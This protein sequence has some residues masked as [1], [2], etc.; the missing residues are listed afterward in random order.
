MNEP[1][2]P[3]PEIMAVFENMTLVENG[4]LHLNFELSLHSPNYFRIAREGYRVLYA[5]MIESLRGTANLD[6]T[7][8]RSGDRSTKFKFGNDPWLEI[9]KVEIQGCNQAWRYSKP[10]PSD[11]PAKLEI[12]DSEDIRQDDYLIGFY[13]ALAMVQADAYMTKLAMSKS[14]PI[15]DEDMKEFE[16]LHEIFRNTFEHFVPRTLGATSGELLMHASRCLTLARELIFESGNVFLFYREG[17]EQSVAQQ[18]ESSLGQ[19]AD[20][21]QK[22]ANAQR[23]ESEGAS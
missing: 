18:F 4:L 7:G 11:P 22:I 5:S 19:I 21:L 9:H 13:D 6:V 23:N 2:K 17:L 16:E 20:E 12:A 8:R 1:G 10:A 14:I 15:S 3:T